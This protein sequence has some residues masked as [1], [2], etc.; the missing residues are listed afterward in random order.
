MNR[1]IYRERY[2]NRLGVALLVSIAAH[3]AFL[4]LLKVDVPPVPERDR[5]RATQLIE[6][7]DVWQDRPLEVVRLSTPPADAS[8]A[9]DA[10]T[11]SRGS[12]AKAEA[13]EPG[14][15]GAQVTV[16]A[17]KA[18]PI[19]AGP[20]ASATELSLA[21]AE[22]VTVASV[23]FKNARRGVVLRAGGGGAAEDVGLDFDA[24]S[25]A[26]RDAERRRGGDGRGGAGGIGVTIFG[27]AG[28]DC[29]TPGS[30]GLPGI[31]GRA[32]GLA[33]LPGSG[34]GR[35]LIGRTGGFGSAINRMAP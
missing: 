25:D 13:S 12:S 10:A 24:A 14:D 16:A 17:S 22:E 27:G 7:A 30:F 32:G 21:L 1:T 26:A 9:A 23:T 2:R 19:L 18:R 11:D 4:V 29:D 15:A 31:S 5:E 8:S 20:A 34:T 33:S 35:G 28:V 6:L 3:V